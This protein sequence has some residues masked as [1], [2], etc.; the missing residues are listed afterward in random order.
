MC[1]GITWE[2]SSRVIGI[3]FVFPWKNVSPT[4]LSSISVSFNWLITDLPW[5]NPPATDHSDWL[6]DLMHSLVLR[7][8]LLDHS[9]ASWNQKETGLMSSGNHHTL[10][11]SL[12]YSLRFFYELWICLK[13]YGC[14]CPGIFPFTSPCLEVCSFSYHHLP[15]SLTQVLSLIVYFSGAITELFFGRKAWRCYTGKIINID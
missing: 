1:V 9:E 7:T 4:S 12:H 15:A 14:H 8:L 6:R 5:N 2:W 11:P 10:P 3:S 13:S